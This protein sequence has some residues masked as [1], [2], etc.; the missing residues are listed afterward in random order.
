MGVDRV[1]KGEEISET[2]H[3]MDTLLDQLQHIYI[4]PS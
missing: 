1:I 2:G 4:H 3:T